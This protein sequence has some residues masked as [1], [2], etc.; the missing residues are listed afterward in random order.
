M[1]GYRDNR[2]T[3]LATNGKGADQP[4]YQN[5]AFQK[6]NLSI[7]TGIPMGG[8]VQQTFMFIRR[9]SATWLG[10]IHNLGVF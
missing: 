10:Y 1:Q 5:H 9:N 4:P 6:H 2:K 8:S 3:F 7:V